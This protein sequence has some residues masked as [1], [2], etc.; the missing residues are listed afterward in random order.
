MGWRRGPAAQ[1]LARTDPIRAGSGDGSG[2]EGS[3]GR[4]SST[5]WG[6]VSSADWRQIVQDVM[7]AQPLMPRA[8]STV[9][10]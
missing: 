8:T 2:A 6:A 9:W 7:V 1:T 5:G 10:I 3:S 4:A